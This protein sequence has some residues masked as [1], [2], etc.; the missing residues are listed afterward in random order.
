M[1]TLIE[2]T[3]SV[4]GPEDPADPIT[5]LQGLRNVRLAGRLTIW[6]TSLTNLEGVENL[7]LY[8]YYKNYALYISDN[9]LL[10]NL[11]GLK[12]QEQIFGFVGIYNNASLETLEGL[13][14]TK[15]IIFG[16]RIRGNPSLRTLEG[17]EDL[18]RVGT[19]VIAENASL[20]HITDLVSLPADRGV[21]LNINDNPA[22]DC[23]L[24]PQ[25]N[26]LPVGR[27]SGNLVD[28]PVT[29]P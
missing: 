24:E 16:L 13:E 21:Y 5:N 4:I 17:L 28:C 12:G 20:E 26:F 8:G 1:Y 2:W 25:P 29:T 9:P 19:T 10:Q 27:S 14:G 15:E 22:L 18:V 23:S 11:Q 6:E 7:E 3:I